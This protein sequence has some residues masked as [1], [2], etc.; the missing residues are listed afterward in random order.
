MKKEGCKRREQLFGV[1]LREMDGLTPLTQRGPKDG[2][3]GAR[4][5]MV[6][7][8][9]RLRGERCVAVACSS[10]SE[11]NRPMS[12]GGGRA[13]GK[14][15]GEGQA[16]GGGARA[17]HESGGSAGGGG[18]R[19]D[20]DDQQGGRGSRDK[21]GLPAVKVEVNTDSEEEEACQA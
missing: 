2:G 19:G 7:G 16:T 9:K 15:S 6:R 11:G 5:E 8:G 1:E 10:K 3:G 12:G 21:R 20:G 17:G 14:R 4:G 13:G 18:K